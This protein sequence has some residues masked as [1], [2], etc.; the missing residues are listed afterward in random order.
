MFLSDPATRP[1]PALQIA[2]VFAISLVLWSVLSAMGTASVT[3]QGTP[4]SSLEIFCEA[5]LGALI[6]SVV[7]AALYAVLLHRPAWLERAGSLVGLFAVTWLLVAPFEVVYRVIGWPSLEAIRM[8]TPHGFGAA[9]RAV[10]PFEWFIDLL[11]LAV[12]FTVQVALCTWRQ[13][14]ARERALDLADKENLRLRLQIEDLRML[15]L[16]AQLEPHFLFNALNAISA[17]VRADDRKTALAGIGRLSALLRYALTASTRAWVSIAD[18]LAFVEDY[19]ALQ[20]LRYGARMQVTITIG[21]DALLAAMCPP[22]LL[23]P[24]VENALRH[25]LDR[26]AGPGDICLELRGA[27]QDLSIVISNSL[28]PPGAAN[29]GLGLGLQHTEAALHLAF[30]ARAALHTRQSDGRYIVELRLPVTIAACA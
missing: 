23:Q 15:G 5:W 19:L 6:Q 26:H 11:L 13:G 1:P 9:L 10:A 18:E 8:A 7:G 16:R 21:D 17:L 27:A 20:R 25:D 14:R 24:L 4:A 22:L 12:T 28:P 3:S 29:P 30:G 2:R